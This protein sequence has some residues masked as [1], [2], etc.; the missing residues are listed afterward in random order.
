MTDDRRQRLSALV[1]GESSASELR[2][3]LAETLLDPELTACWERYFL[4][5]RSLRGEPL[6]TS[7]RQVAANVAE[8]VAR[9]PVPDSIGVPANATAD[10]VQ[11]TPGPASTRRRPAATAAGPIVGVALAAGLA[12]VAVAIGPNLIHRGGLTEPVMVE[13]TPVTPPAI[14][15]SQSLNVIDRW[16]VGEPNV[17]S[18]LNELLVSHRERAAASGISGLIPYAAVVGYAGTR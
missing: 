16:A 3:T 18:K 15:G 8:R 9:E 6:P 10:P 4:I 11:S 1:D 17:A 12:V 7:A 14:L 13:V 2:A 5:G